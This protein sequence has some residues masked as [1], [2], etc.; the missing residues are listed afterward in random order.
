LL[1]LSADL[2]FRH[3]TEIDPCKISNSRIFYKKDANFPIGGHD[4]AANP[5]VEINPKIPKPGEICG[6]VTP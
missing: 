2:R 5:I 1:R 4:R 6:P 3:T